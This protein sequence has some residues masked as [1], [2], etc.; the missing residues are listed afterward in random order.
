M[1][2]KR[3]EELYEI[4]RNTLFN[5]IIPFWVKHSLDKEF[6]GY[7]TWMDRDGTLISTDKSVWIQGRGTWIFSKM[8]NEF[9]SDKV[10]L[11]AAKLGYDFLRKYCY[12][13]D[14]RMF[15]QVTREGKPLRKRRYLFSEAF[16]VIGCAEYA[17]ATGDQ[18]ALKQAK[19]TYN[20]LLDCYMHPEKNPPKVIKETRELKSHSM[21]MIL[22]ATTQSIREVDNNPKYDKIIASLIE[23]LLKD[24]VK[25]DKKVL[26]EN[27][28][29]NGEYIDNPQGRVINPGHAIETSWFLMEEGRKQN[30]QKIINS[31]LEI[32]EWSL[33]IGWD[34]E[35]GGL[36]SF[37]DIEGKP[38][39]QLEWDMKMWWP[40]NEALYALLLAYNLT[41]DEKYLN[42]YEK[43]HEWAFSHFPDPIHGEWFGY[44]HR[45]GTV[46]S[47]IKG[48]MWKG[49]FHVPR[50][51]ILS[52]KLLEE[53]IKK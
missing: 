14:G 53:M 51:F 42:W 19:D 50:Q 46:S 4:Y 23:E 40:H 28:G 20:L 37:L 30:N 34:K 26:L 2:T 18:E 27:V 8:C 6:G 35:F 44:L 52:T 12:D 47:T 16:A 31:A 45:D 48:S 33:E 29:V 5:D 17:K 25:R 36:F 9:G 13:T 10:W 39:E 38:P 3:L 15:F 24:F 21:P 7:L 41:E 43:V 32:M 49:L 1:I 11:S 22:I